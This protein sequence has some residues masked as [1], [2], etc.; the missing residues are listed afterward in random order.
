MSGSEP[1]GGTR[2]VQL[3]VSGM[4][5]ADCVRRAEERLASLD[6]VDEATGNLLSRRIRVAFDPEHVD[7]G[8][9][10]EE[11]GRAGFLAR[12]EEE[13][14][15]ALAPAATWTAP[16]AWRTYVAGL[17]LL[18]GLLLRALGLGGTAVG[19]PGAR[20]GA[21]ELLFVLAALTG[22][23]GFFPAAWRAARTLSLDMNFLMTVA[24]VGAVA[25]G[26]YVEAG[27]IAVLF[28]LAELLEDFAV[29]R[30]RS[31]IRALVGLSPESAILLRGGEELRVAAED[32]HPGDLVAVRAGEK[33]PADGVVVE[34][35]AA[36]DESPITGEA[37][38]RE[39]A[40]GDEVFAGTISAGGYLTLRVEAAAEATTLAGIVRLVEEAQARRSRTE[41]FVERFARVYT[42]AVT[43]A[44]VA[45][46]ALPPL[47]VGAAFDV[48]F[49]RGLTLL[50]IA[51]PCAL[52][53]STPVAVVSG[54]TAAAR[55]GVLIKG[56][57][58]LETLG[59]VAAVALDKTGTLTYGHPV[60]VE[61]A[62]L[63]GTDPREVLALAAAA[64]SRSEHPIGR[65]VVRAAEDRGVEFRARRVTE[66]RAVP[67]KGVEATVDAVPVRVGAAGMFGV[68]DRGG[69]A[70]PAG[71]RP[72]ADDGRAPTGGPGAEGRGGE[73]RGAVLVERAGRLVGT[74]ALED[75]LRQGAARA[76]TDLRRAGARRVVLLTGDA[77][78]VAARVGERL[79]VDEAHGG[80]L[81]EGKV[82]RIGE[83]RRRW[84]PV[85]M[86]GDGVNDGPALAAA[87]VG[88][89]MGA[90]G[91][92]V[93]IETADVA[94]MS[95]DLSRLPYLWRLARRG[96][97]VMR[98][99]VAVAVATKLVLAAGVPFGLVSLVVAVLVGDMGASLAVILNSLRLAKVRPGG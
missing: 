3:R 67:G 46:A 71:S 30:A 63:D 2:R 45:V 88:I 43:V 48:W 38:P 79:G 55:H 35:T 85:A 28:S 92:D 17:L 82:E 24:I 73:G 15:E 58:Y 19:F 23:W 31:S 52:V 87:D 29:D 70:G 25:I 26:E 94:L 90:A 49:V 56:G 65:A 34:G 96:R 27:A 33:V 69:A 14:T 8:R 91:S 7:E 53:I 54:I 9:I 64:E 22:G 57:A 13:P 76:V 6:G 18:S 50:V 37:V 95:D 4:D 89:A 36:V 10:R 83:L 41:R 78:A 80:L 66:F 81:P 11:L 62:G 99:N 21:S 16:D 40:P 5:C 12:S 97:G 44:A 59:R 60:V 93:A 75:R 84:G 42:P 68:S 72:E 77:P 39:K 32:L 20:V 61:V 1:T 74:L 47:L 98:E 51:C 86:V